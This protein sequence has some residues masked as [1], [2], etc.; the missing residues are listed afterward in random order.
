MQLPCPVECE[1]A[2]NLCSVL[3]Q[4]SFAYY[5]KNR[6]AVC[7]LWKL[8]SA[9]TV[10]FCVQ[11]IKELVKKSTGNKMYCI[12]YRLHYHDILCNC[13]I[14]TKW[15]KLSY[16]KEM[17]NLCLN[18]ACCLLGCDTVQLGRNLLTF[19]GICC[20]YLQDHGGNFVHVLW[21]TE[22]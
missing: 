20:F 13:L 5:E 9:V 4:T 6:I 10:L 3:D 8:P 19:G 22:I 11:N 15:N 21:M 17:N 16:M 2:E 1:H 14:R 12:S 18:K 7:G